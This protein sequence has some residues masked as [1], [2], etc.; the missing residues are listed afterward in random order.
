MNYL[1]PA[2]LSILILILSVSTVGAAQDYNSSR[3][4]TTAAIDVPDETEKLLRLAV[5]DATG[6]MRTMHLQDNRDGYQGDY[7]IKVEVQVTLER[8]P[9]RA[10]SMRAQPKP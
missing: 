7:Q 1:T 4:N 5:E 10:E 9:S 3:S 8:A 2:L 6:V